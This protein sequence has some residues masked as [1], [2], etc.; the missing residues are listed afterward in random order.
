[1]S[2]T[3]DP[4][5]HR[6]LVCSVLRG[7]AAGNTGG[8]LAGG[9]PEGAA[10]YALGHGLGPALSRIVADNDSDPKGVLKDSYRRTAAANMVLYRELTRVLGALAGAEPAMPVMVLK[11]CS[12]AA[13]LYD[14]PALRPMCDADI[15]VPG[16]RVEEAVQ[17]V[18]ELGYRDEQPEMGGGLAH[19]ASH[20]VKL[21]SR[22][23]HASAVEIHWTLLGSPG[24]WRSP[25]MDWFWR[26]TEAWRPP[27]DLQKSE[28]ADSLG[29]MVVQLDPTAMLLHLAAHLVLGHGEADGRLLWLYDIHLLVEKAG[30]RVDWEEAAER[31]CDFSWG[32]ALATAL[33][34]SRDSFGTTVDDALIAQ[35]SATVD[36]RSSRFVEIKNQ[37]VQ[38]RLLWNLQHL[39][40]KNWPLRVRML[41]ALLFPSPAYIRWRYNP[42]PAWAWPL[43]YPWRWLD[44]LGD[45][46]RTVYRLAF[47]RASTR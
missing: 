13:W 26:H 15:M 14:S 47:R 19:D 9:D 5:G 43:C 46:A 4:D 44:A 7:N 45:L 16:D 6:A 27:S 31:A 30:D 34:Q 1:M 8:S 40:A 32:P 33:E 42:R 18:R 11:G 10:M 37:P 3:T 22:E 29:G 25:P 28:E 12:L 39:G 38:T 21:V 20:H 2:W 17:R 41:L 35:F 24:D 36:R 23:W